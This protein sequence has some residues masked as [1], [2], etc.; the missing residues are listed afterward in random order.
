MIGPI[1]PPSIA[2]VIYGA[3]A[4]VSIGKLLLGGIIPV[5]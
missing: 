4:N 5:S 3:I 2:L 1:I